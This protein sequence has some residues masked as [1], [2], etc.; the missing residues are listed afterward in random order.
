[1][2]STPK[3]WVPCGSIAPEMM[4]TPTKHNG[5]NETPIRCNRPSGHEGN[6]AWSTQHSARA[7][8]WTPSDLI[9]RT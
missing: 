6:H 9:R 5:R 8:E 1:M 4:K 3:D 7:W 2:K